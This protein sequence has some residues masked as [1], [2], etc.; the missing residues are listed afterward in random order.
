MAQTKVGQASSPDI[1]MT[2]LRATHRQASGG[3][4]SYQ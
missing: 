1:M 2:C 4:L 3:R